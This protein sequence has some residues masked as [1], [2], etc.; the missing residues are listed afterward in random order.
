MAKMSPKLEYC[1]AELRALLKKLKEG[2][3]QKTAE[4]IYD[5]V[6]K[7]GVEM[8]TDPELEKE[9][10]DMETFIQLDE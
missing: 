10:Y 4:F 3:Y 6:A 1:E 8:A 2:Y 9:A 7:T 5:H